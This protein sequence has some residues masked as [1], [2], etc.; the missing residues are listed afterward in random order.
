MAN[1]LHCIVGV[2]A[3]LCD[4]SRVGVHAFLWGLSPIWQ[5]MTG[6]IHQRLCPMVA[7]IHAAFFQH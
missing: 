4:L 3:F 6:Q 1:S 5:F 7:V 2:H